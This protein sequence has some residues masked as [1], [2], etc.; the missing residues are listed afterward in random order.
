MSKYSFGMFKDR[1]RIIS[2]LTIVMMCLL[3]CLGRALAG[4]APGTGMVG[5]IHDLNMFDYVFKDSQQRVCIFCHTPHNANPAAGA[6]WN[7]TIDPTI[8]SLAPYQWVAPTNQ[9]I[10]FN[11]D[12]LM[13]PSRLC[14][15]CHDG[16]IAMDAQGDT[17]ASR[18]PQDVISTNLGTTHP[19]GFS[20]DNAKINRGPAELADKNLYLAT[21]ITISDSPGVYNQVARN[22]NVRI[23]DLLFQGTFITCMTCHDVH[24]D[25]NVSPDPGHDYN[26]L[27]WAKEEQSLIC[28]T[29]HLK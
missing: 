2:A 7:I 18:F 4:S 13:G 3:I 5:S 1:R 21:A 8:L 26:Y 15:T 11:A 24:N 29:C 17:M 19:I 20:Y 10:P 27:L 22:S 9:G 12:P 6:L 14:M 25:Q 23:V 28:L 16:V